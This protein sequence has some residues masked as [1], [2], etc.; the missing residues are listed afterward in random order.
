LIILLF[1]WVIMKLLV[2]VMFPINFQYILPLNWIIV[3][4][5]SCLLIKVL[6]KIYIFPEKILLG[7]KWKVISWSKE[8]LKHQTYGL[9][10]RST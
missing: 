6:I 3:I 5:R 4:Q 9:H 10:I 2:F 1:G 8:A 7:E